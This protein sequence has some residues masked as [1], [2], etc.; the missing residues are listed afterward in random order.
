MRYW[1]AMTTAIMATIGK[2]SLTTSPELV[3]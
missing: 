3:T 1:V 2:V